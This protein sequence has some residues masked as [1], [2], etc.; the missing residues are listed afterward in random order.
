MIPKKKKAIIKVPQTITISQNQNFSSGQSIG[1]S[2]ATDSQLTEYFFF[3]RIF[4]IC[5]NTGKLH[6]RIRY[7]T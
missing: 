6:P 2:I 4:S 3:G 5:K 7:S 1:I